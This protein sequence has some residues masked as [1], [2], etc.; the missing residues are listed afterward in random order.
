MDS[1]FLSIIVYNGRGVVRER[2]DVRLVL[3]PSPMQRI[4]AMEYIIEH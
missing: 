4:S 3:P 1:K 2:I